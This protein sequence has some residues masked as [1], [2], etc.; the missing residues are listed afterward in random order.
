ML[1]QDGPVRFSLHR[2]NFVNIF[3]QA[4]IVLNKTRRVADFVVPPHDQVAPKYR[5][6]D[7]VDLEA[8]GETI[9]DLGH[10]QASSALSSFIENIYTVYP[11]VE[12]SSLWNH[13]REIFRDEINSEDISLPETMVTTI[14]IDVLKA[15]LAIS[16]LVNNRK[17]RTLARYLLRHLHWSVEKMLVGN[18]P[19]LED[20]IMALLLVSRLPRLD[21]MSGGDIAGTV[22]F[23]KEEIVKSWR[24]IHVASNA[25]MQLGLHQR[26][27]ENSDSQEP[28][29]SLLARQVLCSIHV[30][31][32]RCSFATGL[33]PPLRDG[34]VDEGCLQAVLTTFKPSAHMSCSAD[35]F[36]G[37]LDTIPQPHDRM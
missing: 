1:S 32:H 8:I 36:Q 37:R 28:S 6:S 22:V 21:Y 24:M 26:P 5:M 20:A 23:Y 35:R 18:G 11:C 10:D 19:A 9:R 3:D 12:P 25:C 4:T 7:E 30:L 16:F 15:A 27:A 29:S 17:D 14:D 34:D 31:S 33:P 13:L 2:S